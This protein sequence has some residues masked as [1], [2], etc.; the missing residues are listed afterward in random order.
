M[1]Q[2]SLDVYLECTCCEDVLYDANITHNLGKIAKDST[3]LHIAAS[4]WATAVITA[5]CPGCRGH[6]E[7][8]Q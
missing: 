7:E 4:A 6:L 1:E 3:H 2:V 8:N 5:H